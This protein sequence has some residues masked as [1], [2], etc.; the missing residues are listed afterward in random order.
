MS[1]W[2]EADILWTSDNAAPSIECNGPYAASYFH[3]W[4]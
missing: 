2:F 1:F 3:G 4:T